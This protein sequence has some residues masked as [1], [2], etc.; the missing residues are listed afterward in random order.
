MASTDPWSLYSWTVPF[1]ARVATTRFGM[2]VTGGTLRFDTVGRGACGKTVRNVPL[3]ARVAVTLMTT[4]VTPLAG[5]PPWP[6]TVTVFDWN[7]PSGNPVLVSR[8]RTGACEVNPLA[9][10]E[11]SSK[12]PVTSKMTLVLPWA[13]Y[14]STLPSLATGTITRLGRI[15]P[16]SR[17][18]LDAVG[19]V[20]PD[21]N[22]VRYVPAVGSTP[23]TLTTTAVTCDVG[24]LP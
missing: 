6:A 18:M 12:Y 24:T 7:C 2:S 22:T 1:G 16:G 5:T 20:E 14:T 8:V 23:V 19:G 10:V 21:G 13:L 4:A 15:S 17:L 11:P 9:L 3:V